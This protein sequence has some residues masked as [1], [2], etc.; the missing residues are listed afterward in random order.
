M[1]QE[2]Y[3]EALV[4]FF[5]SFKFEKDTVNNLSNTN[6]RI[7]FCYQKLG[8]LKKSILYGQRS[9]KSTPK[10]DKKQLLETSKT[11]GRSL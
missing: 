9:Y 8:N 7:A 5:E 1:S 4:K 10:I 3:A 11:F 6:Y 2:L